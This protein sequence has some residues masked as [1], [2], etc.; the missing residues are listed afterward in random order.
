MP[1]SESYLIVTE[2]CAACV[3]ASDDA[4]V[5]LAA[6]ELLDFEELLFEEAVEDEDELAEVCD[7]VELPV[8]DEVLAVEEDD[9]AELLLD[10]AEV[11]SCCA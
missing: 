9:S 10:V 8:S 3:A 2:S 7:D 11:L 1:V 5:V 4:E 6:D